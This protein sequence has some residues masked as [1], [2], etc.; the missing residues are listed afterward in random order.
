MH[1]ALLPGVLGQHAA[2]F[3][4][5]THKHHK[6]C[7]QPHDD[8]L[9]SAVRT[10][11]LIESTHAQSSLF[12]AAAVSPKALYGGDL[13]DEKQCTLRRLQLTALPGAARSMAT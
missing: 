9:A 12:A 4:V 6:A 2:A 1:C 13:H 7:A 8:V 10:W 11:T 5:T 3:T